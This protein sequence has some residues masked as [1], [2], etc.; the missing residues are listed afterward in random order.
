ME[1]RLRKKEEPTD[2]L[3]RRVL[4][5]GRARQRSSLWRF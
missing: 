5:R 3:A 1:K 2:I 4:G